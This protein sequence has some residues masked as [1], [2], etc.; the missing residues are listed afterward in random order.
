[1]FVSLMLGVLVSSY[2]SR[3]SKAKIGKT[4][5][6]SRVSNAA[7]VLDHFAPYIFPYLFCRLECMIRSQMNPHL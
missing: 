5:T 6:F 2:H 3:D 4:L 1:V 7:G